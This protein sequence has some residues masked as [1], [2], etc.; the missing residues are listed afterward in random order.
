MA[1]GAMNPPESSV[2]NDGLP[3]PGATRFRTYAVIRSCQDKESK[4]KV[5][6][7]VSGTWESDSSSHTQESLLSYSHMESTNL[8]V[9]TGIS[10]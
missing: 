5:D 3:F 6:Q 2:A 8:G 9:E 10:V 7:S 1:G 4:G